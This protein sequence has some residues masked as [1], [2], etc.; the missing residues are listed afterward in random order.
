MGLWHRRRTPAAP[1]VALALA[2]LLAGC[3]DAELP[4]AGEPGR[5]TAITIDSWVPFVM[6]DVRLPDDGAA[7]GPLLLDTGSPLT[8]LDRGATGLTAGHASAE[9]RA[10]GLTFP[11]YPLVVTDVFA[12]EDPCQSRPTAGI[13]GG[14]L[15]RHFRLGLDYKAGRA[16]LFRGPEADD[17]TLDADT[18]P[19]LRVPL[20]VL[21]GGTVAGLAGVEGS[22]GVPGTRLVVARV[23]V[24]GRDA[25]AVI[26][27]GAS[28]NL[29]GTRLLK[30][31]GD[32]GGRPQLC[33][34]GVT[35]LGGA[36]RARVL[37]V[38]SIELGGARV[39]SVAALAAAGLDSLL[40]GLSG[41][42]GREVDL[43]L[44]GSFLREF[45]ARYDY[46]AGWLEL[47]R[48]RSPTHIDRDEFV[49]P[50]FSF[51]EAR[52]V[53]DPKSGADV[54]VGMRVLDVYQDT[55]ASDQ[56]VAA[57]SLVVA[58]DGSSVVGKS[59]EQALQLIRKHAVGETVKL[60]FKATPADIVRQV[61]VERVL[62]E[63]K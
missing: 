2:L 20:E 35:T 58:V 48:Y 49:G 40:A 26:D 53:T 31:L 14:D 37:R 29:I 25:V 27:T 36:V 23:R 12:G 9:L 7:S 18:E 60:S 17:A 52:H 21:G 39:D 56:G 8:L 22:V 50:G 3:G 47:R 19:P 24:E 33:C 43:L 45:T 13:V 4:F 11:G 32:T 59:A 5:A 10:F 30:R 16:Y 55:D 62:P 15:L 63:Y 6:G 54:P 42:I 41:E 61:E 44:G 51:C 38:K 1:L 46:G 34:T 57:G 28:L